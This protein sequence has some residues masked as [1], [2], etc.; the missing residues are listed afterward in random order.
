M[1]DRVHNLGYIFK[2][3]P[4][5]CALVNSHSWGFRCVKMCSVL[6]REI[7]RRCLNRLWN[8]AKEFLECLPKLVAKRLDGDP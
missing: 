1:K 5:G 4:K 2:S 6:G 8:Y 3:T 7:S